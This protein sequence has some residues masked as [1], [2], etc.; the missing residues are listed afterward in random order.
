MI[1]AKHVLNMYLYFAK[2]IKLAMIKLSFHMKLLPF[3]TLLDT[4]Y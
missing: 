2:K 4:S 1:L 3:I